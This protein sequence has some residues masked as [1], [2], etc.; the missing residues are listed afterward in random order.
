[1]L[2]NDKQ[3]NLLGELLGTAM[4][5]IAVV[6]SGIAAQRL[7]TDPG[8]RLLINAFATSGALLALITAFSSICASRF[9]PAVTLL[10]A[11]KGR[12]KP[13]DAAM[14]IAVQILGGILGVLAANVM[15]GASV[16]G[17]STTNRSSGRL[18]FSEVLATVGLLL[19]VDFA[20]RRNTAPVVAAVVAGWIGGAYF[21]TSSTSF[22]N[23]AVTIARSLTDSYTGI[24]PASIVGFISAQLVGTLIAAG[25][26]AVVKDSKA[27]D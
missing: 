27:A 14:E 12:V 18:I 1:M 3:Q 26:I 9:N 21:F 6:G 13:A 7:T 10:A 4:L 15:F 19:I 8:L 25:V 23:P 5:V 2:L 16:L 22:A 20:A 11:T 24:A 17:P